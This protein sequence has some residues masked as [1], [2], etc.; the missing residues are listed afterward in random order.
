MFLRFATQCCAFLYPRWC[1]PRIGRVARRRRVRAGHRSPPSRAFICST[2]A[3]R[4]LLPTRR[5]ASR[6]N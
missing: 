1:Q 4:V 2:S 6:S 5:Y 3:I